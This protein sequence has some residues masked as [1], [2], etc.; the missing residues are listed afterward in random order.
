[1]WQE[2]VLD[3]PKDFSVTGFLLTPRCG[4]LSTGFWISDKE[5]IYIIIVDWVCPSKE[6]GSR[7]FYAFFSL[8]SSLLNIDFLKHIY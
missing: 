6:K 4:S 7:S 3:F 8:M 5:L 2:D 1:M